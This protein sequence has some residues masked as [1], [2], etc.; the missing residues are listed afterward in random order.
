MGVDHLVALRSSGASHCV[1]LSTVSVQT[2]RG[3]QRWRFMLVH[4]L[5]AH[6]ADLVC[7]TVSMMLYMLKSIAMLL[8]TSFLSVPSKPAIREDCPQSFKRRSLPYPSFSLAPPQWH[9]HNA[10]AQSSPFPSSTQSCLPP[11]TRLLIA[12][13]QIRP[14]SAPAR[15]S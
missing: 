6:G 12:H 2:H 7:M 9:L 4:R 8:R 15:A 13:L 11:R 10:R 5:E 14:Y 3:P 1:C